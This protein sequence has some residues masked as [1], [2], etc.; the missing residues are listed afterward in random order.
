MK[1]KHLL[2]ISY[3]KK[4]KKNTVSRNNSKY[5]IIIC[6]NIISILHN[7]NFSNIDFIIGL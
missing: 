6:R 7:K 1:V 2:L 3:L 5:S 4:M